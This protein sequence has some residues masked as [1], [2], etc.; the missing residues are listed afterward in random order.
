MPIPR[1]WLAA[2]LSLLL[3][4]PAAAAP[5][6]PAAP[7]AATPDDDP[8]TDAYRAAREALNRGEYAKAAEL[9]REV[10][11]K[12]PKS[13]VAGDALYWRAFALYRLG[14]STRLRDA[15]A[16][17]DQQEDAYPDAATRRDAA[18]L[19]VRVRSALARGGDAASAAALA[20]A[21]DE[22]AAETL[23]EAGPAIREAMAEA[24]AEMASMD[25]GAAAA[26]S[27]PRPPRPPRAP[28]PPAPLGLP[29]GD[30]DGR[31][32]GSD[33]DDVRVAALNG[34]LQLDAERAAPVLAKVMA[35]RDEASTCL[36]RR[37][38]FLVA[39]RRA[40]ES[41]AILLEAVRTDPDADVRR[42]AVFWLAQVGTERATA[43]LD[44]I[45]RAPGDL[46]LRQR[47]LFALSQR[48]RPTATR[49]LRAVAERADLPD[50]LRATAIFWLGE[51][52]QAEGPFLAELY[53]RVEGAEL[54][55]R[56]LFSAAKGGAE[57]TKLLWQVAGD[58]KEAIGRRKTALFWLGQRDG[59]AKALAGLYGTFTERELKEQVLFALSQGRDRAR[60]DQLIEIVRKEQD[61]ALRRRAIFWLGQTGDPRAAEVLGELV[62]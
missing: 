44:S 49:A 31:C 10:A 6:I 57:G 51:R 43:L 52:G 62:Q 55:E 59:D 33:D 5:P 50:A 28:Q 38:V 35:R 20:M 22:L 27:A 14:G 15:L 34:L 13:R 24:Q 1:P 32:R 4:G 29:R 39:Q 11:A 9:F 23:R 8:A 54:K 47:A 58:P 48:E 17:L 61:P 53:G 56:V 2:G 21:A 60:T 36:R 3:A 16:A 42:Q 19:A 40:A 12:H 41:E 45:V 18:S 30:D 37:A 46:D 25:A 7:A 26:A